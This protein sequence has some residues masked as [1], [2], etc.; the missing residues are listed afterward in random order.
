MATREM[1]T[2]PTRKLLGVIDDPDRAR[3]AA[4]ALEATGVPAAHIR[5]LLGDEGRADLEQLGSRPNLLSRVVRVFQF[6][7]MDQLPDFLVYERAL[8][9]GR[10][11]IAVHVANRDAMVA[12][13]TVLD[14]YGAHFLNHYG[15][16]HTEELSLWRGPEPEIPGALRR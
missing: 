13:R 1:I 11:V 2:Y 8:L 9:D 7:Y 16:F 4:A 5:L 6:M 14:R 10:A 12:A 3:D 15:R